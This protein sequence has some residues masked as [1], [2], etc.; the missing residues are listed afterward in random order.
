[1][2]ITCLPSCIQ[3]KRIQTKDCFMTGTHGHANP[4][5]I[6]SPRVYKTSTSCIIRKIMLS[7]STSAWRH[8]GHL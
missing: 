6:L 4:S 2:N 8:F 3:S 5:Y 7:S 1:M